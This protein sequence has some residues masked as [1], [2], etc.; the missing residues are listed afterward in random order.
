MTV[1]NYRDPIG[2]FDVAGFLID[3]E[4]GEISDPQII[5]E[6]FQKLIDLGV[7]WQLQGSYGRVA[8]ELI[9]SGAC[10]RFPRK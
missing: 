8:M 10:Q 1:T 7:V 4:A 6:G 2:K 9:R 3:Y 5:A